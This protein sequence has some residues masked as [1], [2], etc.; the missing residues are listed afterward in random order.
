MKI[1]YKFKIIEQVI[2]V[3]IIAVLAPMITSGIIINNIN[4]QAMRK[5][6]I[7]SAV[8]IANMVSDEID[9]FFKV[10]NGVLTQINTTFRWSRY[11]QLH[12]LNLDA[13]KSWK[14]L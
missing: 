5:Q 9:V 14:S 4:Q 13:G 11:T 3:S 10:V 1:N 12:G 8:L 6:L 7:N 2:I